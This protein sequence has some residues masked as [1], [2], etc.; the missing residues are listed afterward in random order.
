[1]ERL[2][3]LVPL[4]FASAERAITSLHLFAIVLPQMLAHIETKLADERLA[5]AQR[6]RLRMR[7]GL[8]RRTRAPLVNALVGI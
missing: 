8:I 3:P 2:E 1:M 5:A 4:L 6:Q 7:A